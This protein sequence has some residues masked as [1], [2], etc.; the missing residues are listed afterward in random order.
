[1]S[2]KLCPFCGGDAY[3]SKRWDSDG[4]HTWVY[5]C[6]AKCKVETCGKWYTGNNDCPNFYAEVRNQWNIRIDE[7]RRQNI[8]VL[9]VIRQEWIIYI[10]HLKN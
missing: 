8:L 2:L 3:I 4:D 7:A 1:M 9:R 6:C 5:V 10:L